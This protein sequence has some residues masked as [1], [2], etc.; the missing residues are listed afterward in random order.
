M[1]KRVRKVKRVRVGSRLKSID[2]TQGAEG[3][4]AGAFQAWSPRLKVP[5]WTGTR[6]FPPRSTWARTASSGVG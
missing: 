3:S 6:S 1:A 5:Q 2:K 4:S